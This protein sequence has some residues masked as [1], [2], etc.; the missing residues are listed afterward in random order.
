MRGTYLCTSAGTSLNEAGK[1]GCA[2]RPVLKQ[3]NMAS[4]FDIGI[5]VRRSYGDQY[6][7]IFYP[8][9]STDSI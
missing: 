1:D 4:I 6:A 9:I 2:G 7:S 5:S 3:Q 8:F